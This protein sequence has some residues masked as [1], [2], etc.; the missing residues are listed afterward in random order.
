[1]FSAST[2]ASKCLASKK[3]QVFSREKILF[4]SPFHPSKLMAK[5]NI[6]AQRGQCV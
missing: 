5:R 4:Y 6:L 2:K 1:M 3:T